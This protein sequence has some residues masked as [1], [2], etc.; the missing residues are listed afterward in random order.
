MIKKTYKQKNKKYK[1]NS[2]L[3]AMIKIPVLNCLSVGHCML[4][5]TLTRPSTDEAYTFSGVST[6]SC[7]KNLLS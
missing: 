3:H 4:I 7:L 5:L 6:P 1:S 2:A